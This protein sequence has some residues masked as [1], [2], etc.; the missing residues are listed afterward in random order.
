MSHSCKVLTAIVSTWLLTSSVLCLPAAGR[1]AS[2]VL[3]PQKTPAELGKWTLLPPESLL[4]EGDAVPLYEKAIQSLPDKASDEQI[5]KWLD[6]PIDQMPLDQVEQALSKYM[7]SLKSVAK[8]VKCRQCNWPEWT[9][10]MDVPNLNEYRRLAF[11]VRLWAKLEI[12]GEGYEGAILALQTELGMS[13]HIG[14]A[15]TILQVLVGTAIGGLGCGQ[16]EEFVQ[17]EGA[18]NLYPALASLPKPFVMMEKAIETEKKAAGSQVGVEGQLDAAHDRCRVIV[19]RFEAN[20]AAL[21]CVEAIRS[22]AAS[23]GGQ[24][25]QTLAD[26]T[27]VSIPRDPMSDESFRYTRSGSTAV[28]ESAVPAGGSEKD[29]TRYEIA[30][31][32]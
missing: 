30:I 10:G 16:I 9:P 26:I 4:I 32:N 3:H 29:R 1:D 5:H 13:R 22:Y 17:G 6:M 15:P 27:E 12:A 25:P 8:A 14:Q 19:K 24:L 23:H 2:L 21:Q 28:L 7:D 31:K 20:L 11:V 18:P